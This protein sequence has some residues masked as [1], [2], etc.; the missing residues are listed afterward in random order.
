MAY[1]STAFAYARIAGMLAG[2]PRIPISTWLSNTLQERVPSTDPTTMDGGTDVAQIEQ[3][4]ES[5]I[6]DATVAAILTRTFPVTVVSKDGT[7]VV[8]SQGG[9]SIKEGARYAVVLMGKEMIDPQT[10]RSL[11]RTESPCCEVVI[12]RVAAAMAYGHLENVKASLDTV[13][14]PPYKSEND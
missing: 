5:A 10:Q 4:M 2:V 8:L 14:P 7:T 3:R 1:K 9:Q 12:D 6:A 11:G 13:A